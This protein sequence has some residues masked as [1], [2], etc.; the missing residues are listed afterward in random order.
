MD[1]PKLYIS[2]PDAPLPIVLPG[3]W[4]IVN[5]GDPLSV[6]GPESDLKMSFLARPVMGDIDDLI[7]AAWQEVEPG[8]NVAV[9]QKVEMP[10][11]DG[12]DRAIQIAYDTAE[13]ESR[14]VF[15]IARM[16]GG[17]AYITLINGTKAGFS[18]RLA[19]IAELNNGWKPTGLKEPSLAG[20][21]PRKFGD[22]EGKA[23]GSFVDWAMRSIGIPGAAVAVVQDGRTVYAEGFGVCRAGAGEP[24]KTDTR[25]MIGSST[26]PLT[27]F[28]MA[29][30]VDLGRFSWTTPVTHVLSGFALADEEVTRRLEMRHTVCACT[31]MPRRDAD[32]VFR[33]RDVRPE[34]RI[35]EMRQMNPTTGF[36]E[37]FQYSN[38]L[39]AA[40]G[41]AA[42]HSYAPDLP[43]QDAYERSM[44]ELVF[45]PL[46]M[47]Q[48]SVRCIDSPLDAAPHGRNL[49]GNCVPIDS[50]LEK[51][52]DAVAPAGSLWSNILDM[53]Q[54][55]KCELRNGLNDRGEQVISAESLLARRRSAVKIDGKS[56]YGLGLL[57]TEQQGLVQVTHGGNT[58]GFS[59]DMF[60]F[61]EHG[62]GMVILTN[63]RAANLFL[64]SVGQRL[65]ELLFGAE[66]KAEAMV[67]AAKKALDDALEGIRRRVK[68][69]ATATTWIGDFTG[70]YIS[71][72]LGPACISQIGEAFQIE[73]ESWSS[74]LGVEEQ[75]SKSRQI[76][77]TSPPWLGTI[78]L[79][80][81]D[82][83]N[84]L[85]LDGGQTRYEFVR[86]EEKH[87]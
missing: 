57:L 41:Y 56:S 85:L 78:K 86:V 48:T 1:K 60:F 19:H 24:V 66:C 50:V 27:T 9:R 67:T 34:D 54:Y 14:V 15:A 36:G 81:T 45:E 71:E 20:I 39:V 38:Y 63:L 18:R 11:R 73:F 28:M 8:F 2:L 5:Q 13:S 74:N 40:G 51:F 83:P 35:A 62:V 42:A 23:I 53:A 77:L 21:S 29:R 65:V 84:V 26:K 72:E 10:T 70:H 43:L 7:R 31:G 61:P 32:L 49:N 69:E 79:Q 80:L 82:N 12:W 59:A 47:S 75:S 6:I 4:N 17:H 46:G 22:D 16:L 68:I 44:Q 55:V 30:L 37:T 58:L 3:G 33:F 64:A 25:F 76:V 52:A 87:S